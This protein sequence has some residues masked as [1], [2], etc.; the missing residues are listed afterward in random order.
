MHDIP[1]VS[2]R[3][4]ESGFLSWIDVSRLGTEQGVSDY[5]LEHAKVALN[6]GTPYGEQGR[7]HL[8]IVQGAIGSD[9]EI[10]KVL[11]RMRSALLELSK[12]RGLY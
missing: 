2:M 9:E 8:R 7:G 12:T 3:L 1:G 5:L 11:T 10:E 4:S 6:I